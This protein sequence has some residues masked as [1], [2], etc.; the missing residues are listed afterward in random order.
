MSSY[1]SFTFNSSTSEPPTGNQLRINN[2][3]QT[4][5]TRLWV[6]KTTTDGLDVAIGL[7]KIREGHLIYIQDRDDA[8]R[9][10][11]YAVTADGVDD[12]SYY[13]F[14][15]AYDSGPANVPFQTV[16]MQA[17]SSAATRT[18]AGGTTGQVL[19]KESN[20]DYD[21]EWADMPQIV[22]VPDASWPPASPQPNVLY[23]RLAP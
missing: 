5:A 11:K 10:V 14:A 16:E 3:S 1:V 4:A 13:D 17:L 9:W 23:L 21:L 7:A 19:V 12:G 18:S 8:S 15:V 6:T 2:A 22:G 20:A